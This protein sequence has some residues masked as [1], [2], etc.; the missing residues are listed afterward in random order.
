[1]IYDVAI[2]GGGPGGYT[3]A[4]YCVRSGLSAVVLEKLSP[5]GQMA[6]TNIVDNYPGFEEGIDGFTLGQKMKAGAERFGAQ[7]VLAEVKSADLKSKIKKIDSSEGV[8]E[9]KTVII[10]TGA[11]A[12]KLGLPEETQLAGKGVAYCATCDG[13]F[14]KNKTVAVVGGGNSAVADALYLSNICKEVYLIH[15]RG[16]LRASA[17]YMNALKA[18]GNVHLVWNSVVS[19]LLYDKTLTGITVQNVESGETSNIECSGLFVAVGRL[20]NTALF[21]DTVEL[22]ESG[23]IVAD[24][25][26]RTNIPGVFAVGDVRTKALRQ[27]VTACADGAVASR[28]IEDYIRE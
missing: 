14:Y 28:Y 6:A 21:K 18:A 26:T 17:V 13:M 12:K 3:A 24:E 16:E 5:G 2:I 23:Y 25:S 22:D 27:I 8:F 10:A 19:K 4:L 15:R 1:M 20:P 9:A 7:T 11:E